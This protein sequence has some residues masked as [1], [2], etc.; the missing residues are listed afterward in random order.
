MKLALLLA[1]L[2]AVGCN[3]AA[4]TC[5]GEHV[6][7]AG[8]AV[9]GPGPNCAACWSCRDFGESPGWVVV[10]PMCDAP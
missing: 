9:C 2:V 7:D 4:A 3:D 1:A 5:R 8:I 6:P 10:P